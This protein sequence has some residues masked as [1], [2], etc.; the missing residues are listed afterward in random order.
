MKSRIITALIAAAGMAAVTQPA[1]A[2]PNGY[3][4]VWIENHRICKI[5]T[6]KLGLKAK[7]GKQLQKQNTFKARAAAPARRAAR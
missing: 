2:C 4:S 7:Q 3:E 1:A 5:K 6:P